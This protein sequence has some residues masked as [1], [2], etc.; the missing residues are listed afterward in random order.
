MIAAQFALYPLGVAHLGPILE[1]AI[2]ATRAT[3]VAVEVGAMSSVLQGEEDQVFGALRAAWEAAAGHGAT[4]LVVSVSNAC[5]VP[6][7]AVG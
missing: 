7:P 1:E 4:V 2:A 5:P 3:G 6:S